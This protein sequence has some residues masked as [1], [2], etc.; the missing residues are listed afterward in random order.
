MAVLASS[1]ARVCNISLS[2]GIF[3][4]IF[5]QAVL[6]PVFKGSGKDPRN[7]GTYRPI[8]ILPSLSK[9]L[10]IAVRDSLVDW[11]K[12]KDFIPDS[13]FG[14]LPGRS[15]TMA[16]TCAQTDWMKAKSNGEVVGVLAFDLSAAFDIVD[17]DN[18][19]AKLECAGITGTSLKWFESY[20]TCRSQKVLWNE[21]TSNSGPLTHGL[22]Q[23]S[24]LGP[25]LFLVMISDMPKF[26]IGDTPNAKMFGYAD[27][28]TV[29]V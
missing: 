27:D 13:Q 16:L 9:I 1:I 20:M 15:V 21:Q 14:F 18:L 26:V 24:I 17:S 10:E 8:S 28:S 12:L 7:P 19:L 6:H 4:D 29:L 3:P 2:S 23:G 22:P 11:L 25:T 5:K